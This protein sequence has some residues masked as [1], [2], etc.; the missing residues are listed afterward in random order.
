MAVSPAGRRETA[1]LLPALRFAA[2]VAAVSAVGIMADLST[3][4][5]GGLRQRAASAGVAAQQIEDARDSDDPK[6]ELIALISAAAP[7]ALNTMSVG[8]LRQRAASAGVAAQQ[9]E[10]AR[11]SDDP[12]GELINLITGAELGSMSV[13]DL[14]Q[15]AASA[16]V[17]ASRIEVARDSE[18]PKS[19]LIALISGG[20]PPQMK[21]QSVPVVAAAVPPAAT[22]APVINVNIAA[23]PGA[24]GGASDKSKPLMTTCRTKSVWILGIIYVRARR[25]CASCCAWLVCIDGWV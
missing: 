24:A 10:D 8:G 9:I 11:D 22:I 5:V 19:A 1:T 4:S 7:P 13:R 25:C 15:R 17:S 16:G 20:Q 21:S 2:P 3:M 6:G 12:K 14:R 23:P 18:D